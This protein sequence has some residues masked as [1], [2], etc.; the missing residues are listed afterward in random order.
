MTT[1]PLCRVGVS[2][3]I[4][5]ILL[6]YNAYVNKINVKYRLYPNH[7]QQRT[8]HETLAVCRDVYNSLV[9]ERT[10]CHETQGK[11]PTLYQQQKAMTAWKPNNAELKTVHS[12]VLQNVAV[13]VE[14]AFQA[15]FRRVKAGEEPGY[16]RLKG[17]DQYDSITYPQEGYSVGQ[18]TVTLSKIGQVKAKVHRPCPGTIK[19]CTVRKDGEKWYVCFACEYEA[20][21][22][23]ENTESVGIDVGL[24]TFSALS[25]G[26]FIENPR[27]F[28]KEETALAKAQ[29]KFDKVKNKHGSK[30]RRAAK[31][32]VRRVHERIKNRRH[33]FVHQQSRKLVNRFGVI[34]VEKLNVKGMVQNH[35]LAKSISDA[36]WTQF[37]KTLTMKAESAG[38]LVIAVNPAHTSQDCH[39]C[40]YRAKKRLSERWHH[41][42]MCGLRLDRDTNA[43]VNILALGQ[44]SVAC[45]KA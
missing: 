25:N 38:R 28:R 7:A 11:A 27:F 17:N 32:V 20:E 18:S 45:E 41:C 30:E 44:Q 34:A 6:E 42:P 4:F 35:C 14:L 43:A 40:G 12:Q 1:N 24:K 2:L 13:R 10:V 3:V 39:A 15:F 37:R 26:E 36:S 31:K 19:T 33:N 8:L 9:H 16:P 22:L 21:H 5:Y 29:R 23:P